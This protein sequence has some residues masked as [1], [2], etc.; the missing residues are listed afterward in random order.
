MAR[1]EFANSRELEGYFAA[2][3]GFADWFNRALSGR[4]PFVRPSGGGALRVPTSDAARR[5]FRGF[6]DRPDLAYALPRISLLEFASLMAIVLNET[7]GDFAPF[8]ERGGRG[9]TDARGPHPGLA[10]F[11]DRIELPTLHK[12][13]YNH[14]TGGRTAGNLFNDDVYVVAHGALGGA[15]RLARRGDDYGG[16]WNSHFYP[17][18]QFSTDE[19][20]PETAFIREAD[21]YKFR[22]RGIIQT[23]GRASYIHLV[24]HVRAYRGTDPVLSALAR[25]W[26]PLTDQNACTTSTNAD[27]EQLFAVPEILALAFALHSGGRNG[28][29]MMSRQA[30][31]LNGVPAAGRQGT[32]GSIYQMGRRISGSPAYGRGLYRDRVL[33]LLRAMLAVVAAG[34]N[35]AASPP[36]RAPA[37]SPEPAPAA[38]APRPGQELEHRTRPPDPAP[39]AAAPRRPGPVP[40]PIRRPCARNGRPTRAR[41]AISRTGRTSISNSARHSRSAASPT[42]PPISPTTSPA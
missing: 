4:P 38:P 33:A 34:T 42:R 3:G 18:D 13:S 31:I 30:E 35:P 20:D 2:A 29:R 36:G 32:P 1:C 41:T 39:P 26:A 22:G 27:W 25:R 6:W 12:A 19:R 23:T 5:R 14:M 16:A 40:P 24:R 9:R 28:Y 11:F 8:V 17:Q 21:F 15:A 10:Y 37:S 7:D